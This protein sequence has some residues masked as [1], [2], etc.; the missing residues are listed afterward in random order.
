MP[1]P[2]TYILLEK[3]EELEFNYESFYNLIDNLE[4]TLNNIIIDIKGIKSVGSEI[5]GS[6]S[7]DSLEKTC[8]KYLEKIRKWKGDQKKYSWSDPKIQNEIK[9]IRKEILE[10]SK[11]IKE[12]KE[13]GREEILGKN[14][15]LRG[16]NSYFD[17]AE[18]L[19]QRA[20]AKLLEVS[21][22]RSQE[23]KVSKMQ[24][25][26]DLLAANK[27]D[28]ATIDLVA[29]KGE[30]RANEKDND[31][32]KRMKD[33]T[34]QNS[35]IRAGM[36]SYLAN[37]LGVTATEIEDKWTKGEEKDKV[38]ARKY[39]LKA[40]LSFIE[41]VTGR[42]Y[43]KNAPW[44]DESYL[45]ELKSLSTYSPGFKN[46]KP[47]K[48]DKKSEGITKE[49]KKV[50]A[51]AAKPIVDEI[52]KTLGDLVKANQG[53]TLKEKA[54]LDEVTNNENKIN[55]VDLGTCC[56]IAVMDSLYRTKG[57]IEKNIEAN[58]KFLKKVDKELL[59]KVIDQI[60]IMMD[61]CN[62]KKYRKKEG[63]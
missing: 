32:E 34:E 20:T 49:E 15:S 41:S 53:K 30:K 10:E 63:K 7:L 8:N 25:N 5:F 27:F 47:R 28:T 11:N 62:D 16:A 2:I 51:E 57:E 12:I 33:E 14:D 55:N 46:Y 40:A 29:K 6:S 23:I 52:K 17:T 50:I 36:F 9:E 26:T 38:A 42:T 61:Y 45:N 60:G 35:R 13:K 1:K 3:K 58:S 56:D 39:Y 54:V 19:R 31:Y 22:I 44:E 59:S 43:D 37:I 21:T 18:T 24:D 4:A 48:E